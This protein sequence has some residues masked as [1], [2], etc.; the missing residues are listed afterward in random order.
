MKTVESA[1]SQ[2]KE[3]VQHAKKVL[4]VT[5]TQASTDGVAATLALAESIKAFGR[6]VVLAVPDKLPENLSVLPG[7]DKF[8]T[9]LGPKS[10]V[11]SLDYEPG[12]ISKV[13]YG[14]Q[15]KKFNLVVT[16]SNGAN[17]TPENVN[18]S[19]SGG[20][21]NLVMVL[22]T[23]DPAL[24]GHLYEQEK[25]TLEHLPVINI[26]RHPANTQFGKVN[27]LDHEATTTSEI[28]SRIISATKLPLPKISAELLLLGI[29]EGT[30]NFQ[31]AGPGSFE[32]A[33]YLSR[34]IKGG[35]GDESTEERL[36]NEPFR[37]TDRINL[38]TKTA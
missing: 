36:V 33:A 32:S 29:R 26:D 6:E 18:F 21:Y 2:I 4:L 23:A 13:S 8:T 14:T 12:S 28:V 24:L 22:D 11:I 10:L 25:E 19:Y 30:T 16:P 34:K 20:D 17:V 7:A 3:L 5:R 37:R 35:P 31:N 15:G 38:G 27:A 9:N 1:A